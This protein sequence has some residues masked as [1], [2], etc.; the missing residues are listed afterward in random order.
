MCSTTPVALITGTTPVTVREASRAARPRSTSGSGGASP[1]AAAARASSSTRVSS[2]F[3]TGRPRASAARRPGSER[4]RASTDGSVR[5]SP[6]SALIVWAAYSAGPAP[7]PTRRPVPPGP[8]GP[9]SGPPPGRWLGRWLGRWTLSAGACEDEPRWIP[10]NDPPSRA[11]KSRRWSAA[12]GST[13]R[14]SPRE[15]SEPRR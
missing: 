11:P 2:A 6:G 9:R 3:S 1:F 8:R 14:S 10:G 13:S 12:G 15:G 7:H 5:R 4:S